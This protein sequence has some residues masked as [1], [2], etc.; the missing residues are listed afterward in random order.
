MS[1]PT[2]K[3]VLNGVIT[4]AYL[5][6]FWYDSIASS[7]ADNALD[8]SHVAQYSFLGIRFS[9]APQHLLRYATS[10]R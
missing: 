8:S 4:V 6:V 3:L 9:P 5:L 7:K 2:F 1:R 10:C